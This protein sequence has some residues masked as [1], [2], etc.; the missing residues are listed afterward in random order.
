M[1]TH[2]LAW[3][4]T[5]YA[6]FTDN[7]LQYKINDAHV[8]WDCL[9][10]SSQTVCHCPSERD[11]SCEILLKSLLD[12]ILSDAFISDWE[13]NLKSLLK[14]LVSNSVVGKHTEKHILLSKPGLPNKVGLNLAFSCIN[15]RKKTSSTAAETGVVCIS[16][17][18]EKAEG[19]SKTA[20]LLPKGLTVFEGVNKEEASKNVVPSVQRRR[21]TN[22]SVSSD[23]PS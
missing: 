6:I 2:H 13:A 1:K 22:L 4:S 8:D 7:D 15:T 19:R 23:V 17:I 5:V 9:P 3:H 16:A 20:H 14:A 12:L 21:E 10:E 18:P 11:V